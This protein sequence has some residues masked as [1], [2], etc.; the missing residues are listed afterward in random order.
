[1]C[2]VLSEVEPNVCACKSEVKVND[3]E[4]IKYVFHVSFMYLGFYNEWIIY[5]VRVSNCICD[6]FLC[7]TSA[8]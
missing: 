1:M 6:L 2:Q 4:V 3:A 7:Q 8:Q 5:I